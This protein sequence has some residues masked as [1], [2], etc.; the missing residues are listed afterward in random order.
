MA[1]FVFIHHLGVRNITVRQY[2]INIVDDLFYHRIDF[3]A[4]LIKGG[5]NKMYLK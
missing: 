5:P 2:T 1:S 3:M 4:V